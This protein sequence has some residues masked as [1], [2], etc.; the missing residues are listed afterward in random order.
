VFQKWQ[1]FGIKIISKKTGKYFE[2]LIF[3]NICQI[4]HKLATLVVAP[5]FFISRVVRC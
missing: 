2:R 5:A 4:S 1:M 3:S